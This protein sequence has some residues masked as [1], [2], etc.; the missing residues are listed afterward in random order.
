MSHL[1]NVENIYQKLITLNH[2]SISSKIYCEKRLIGSSKDQGKERFDSYWSWTK[3]IVCN[4]VLDCSIKLRV[5]QDI[6]KDKQ[7]F[8]LEEI[9]EKSIQGLK[10]GEVI[11]GK[12]KLTLRESCNKIIHATKVIPIWDEE[13][14]DINYKFWSG[15][16]GCTEIR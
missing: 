4:S 15:K 7:E 10:I 5:I 16:V 9:D 1:I 8:K 13:S 2:Y 6:L 3:S 12:I 14:K 11:K